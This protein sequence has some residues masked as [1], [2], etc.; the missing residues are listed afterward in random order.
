MIAVPKGKLKARML[1]YFRQV[2]ES[3]E[4][5]IVTDNRVPVLKVIPIR[6][7][8]TVEEAFGD[9][10]GKIHYRGDLREPE[11]GEWQEK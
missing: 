10:R 8:L 7:K 5:L 1:E 2:E 6:R 9:L 4:E 11:S 3:G